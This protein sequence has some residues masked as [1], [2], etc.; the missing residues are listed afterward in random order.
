MPGIMA[1]PISCV[2]VHESRLGRGLSHTHLWQGK[3]G[4]GTDW[5]STA[6]VEAEERVT[7][8]ETGPQHWTVAHGMAIVCSQAAPD[9]H[10]HSDSGPETQCLMPAPALG[11]PTLRL[12]PEPV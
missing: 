1:L 12:E 5:V 10:T 11:G 6:M 8:T 9:T 2:I 7:S 3:P 4:T